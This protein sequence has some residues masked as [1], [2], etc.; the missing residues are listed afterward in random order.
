[1]K[2]Y[3][4]DWRVQIVLQIVIMLCT[5]YI[6]LFNMLGSSQEYKMLALFLAPGLQAL[7][8][9]CTLFINPNGTPAYTATQRKELSHETRT[10]ETSV[11]P[12]ARHDN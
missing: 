9:A 3:L 5:G 12:P 7:A 4:G 2:D 6:Q 11:D 1:M 10:N 8:A